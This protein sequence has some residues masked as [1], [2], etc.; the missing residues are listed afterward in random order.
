M[1]CA[2]E[3]TASDPPAPPPTHPPTCSLPNNPEMT[4]YV[5]PVLNCIR[6]GIS[7]LEVEHS[8]GAAG[9]SGWLSL[10]M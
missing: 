7:K 2:E 4:A 6:V 9:G 3:S 8:I 10:D 1:L 5:S